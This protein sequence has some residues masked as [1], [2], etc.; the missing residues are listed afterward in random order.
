MFNSAAFIAIY[1]ECYP[2]NVPFKYFKAAF[3]IDTAVHPLEIVSLKPRDQRSGD[4]YTLKRRHFVSEIMAK[5]KNVNN[6]VWNQ[7]PAGSA[8]FENKETI[9]S[10]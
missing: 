4:D 5:R 2:K 9:Q 10:L 1:I 7:W 3:P 6:F 8:S